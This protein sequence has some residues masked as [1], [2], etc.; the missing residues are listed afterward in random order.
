LKSPVLDSFAVLAFLFQENGHE[1]VTDLLERAVESDTSLLVA[2]PNWAE[3]CYIVERKVGAARWRE[4]R[5]KLLSLPIDI[6]PVDRGLAE[7]AGEIKA[8]KGMSLADCFV[9]AMAL[10]KNTEI[11]TGDPEFRAVEKEIRV[12]WL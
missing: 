7:L 2:A 6:L 9:A 1:K 12:N 3:V 4:V 8:K 5:A 10:Q 11:Y